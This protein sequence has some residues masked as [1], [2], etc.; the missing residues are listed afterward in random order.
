MPKKKPFSGPCIAH[1]SNHEP[2]V[3]FCDLRPRGGAFRPAFAEPNKISKNEIIERINQG[4]LSAIILSNRPNPSSYY[5]SE[6]LTETSA[7]EGGTE[8][9][10]ES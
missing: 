5:Y 9:I 8:T 6:P 2:I 10:K 4:Y 1:G 3:A 7:S